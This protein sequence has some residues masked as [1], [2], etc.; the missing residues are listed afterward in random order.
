MRRG[1]RYDDLTEQEKASF[2]DTFADDDSVDFTGA[3]IPGSKLGRNIINLGTIDA[4]LDDLMQNGLK[5]DGGDTIGKT[6]IFAAKPRSGGE[7]C[8]AIPEDLSAMGDGFL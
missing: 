5:V 6:I 1:I 2:E 3:E 7:D 8:R 4:M